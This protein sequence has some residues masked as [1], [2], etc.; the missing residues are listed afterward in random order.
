M[1]EIPMVLLWRWL[2]EGTVLVP[3]SLAAGLLDLGEVF[4]STEL[5]QVCGPVP[6]SGTVWPG[7]PEQR[8]GVRA[9]SRPVLH[10]PV[11]PPISG[12]LTS[13]KRAL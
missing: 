11:L 10:Y 1:N 7:R 2:R 5:Q 9:A 8:P 12:K 4:P 3:A 6:G 13:N